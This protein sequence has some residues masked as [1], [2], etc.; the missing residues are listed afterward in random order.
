MLRNVLEVKL[1]EGSVFTGCMTDALF[2]YTDKVLGV[3]KSEFVGD[4][5]DGLAFIEDAL[6]R[7]PF[8]VFI[9]GMF[10]LILN[11]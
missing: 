11:F 5:A 7:Q 3:F 9:D 2:E 8:A 6:L 1:V 10:Q 4:L